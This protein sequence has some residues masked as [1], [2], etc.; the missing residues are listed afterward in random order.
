M[1]G[2][3]ECQMLVHLIANDQEIALHRQVR[4]RGKIVSIQHGPGGIVR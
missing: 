2:V 4:D 1:F 3:V